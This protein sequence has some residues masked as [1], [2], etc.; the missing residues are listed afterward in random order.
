MRIPHS[1]AF[2]SASRCSSNVCFCSVSVDRGLGRLRSSRRASSAKY[3][4]ASFRR[5]S[6]QICRFAERL[7]AACRLAF[8]AVWASASAAAIQVV[9]QG[10]LR[11]GPAVANRQVTAANTFTV[12]VDPTRPLDFSKLSWTYYS[13]RSVPPRR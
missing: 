5:S 11:F 12:L 3:V 13:K 1:V 7:S 8:F 6:I 10:E 4:A 2:K 9:G